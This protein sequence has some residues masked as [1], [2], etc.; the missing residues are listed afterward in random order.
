[1]RRASPLLAMIASLA[2]PAASFAADP[3]DAPEVVICGPH[4]RALAHWIAAVTSGRLP[5]EGVTVVH[6][7]AHPD[8]SLPRA[9]FPRG[10]RDDARAV[11][12][13]THIASFQ[14]AAVRMGFV[15]EIVWLRPRWAETFPDGPRTFQ[16]GELASG[17]LA[18][19]DPSDHYVLDE[20]WAPGAALRDTQPVQF[21]VIPLD[22]A[23]QTGLLAA[24]PV[25]L[26]IDLDVFATRNPYA[27]RLRRAGFT[28]ADLDALRRIFTP[29]GLALASDP[30][31]RVAE[32]RAL[33]DAVAA[34]AN[35]EWT[36][37]PSA[38]VVFWQRGIG[39]GDLAS[40]YEITSRAS[41]S[42]ASLDAL[43]ADA[44]QVIG[45]PERAADPAEI[46]ATAQQIRA[47]LET[48]ALRPALVTI[49]R[50]VGDGFTPRDAWPLIEWSLLNSLQA[51]LPPGAVVRFDAGEAP[52]PYA[53]P[54]Q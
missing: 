1:M 11:L 30:A 44:R 8:L 21:R 10:F 29:S 18:V 35:G 49:A 14:L 26:D 23:A 27:D 7:D 17:E 13:H 45:L 40:L 46:A 36:S 50:S 33:T 38:L 39:P 2:L 34:L 25:I 51:A 48:G 32:V 53:P 52:A 16:M 19:D 22:T 47:L 12:A 24:S 6:V 37:L 31:T 5:R 15:D 20:G 42:A 28:D 4:D 41:L 43:F 9:P 3:A 54:A